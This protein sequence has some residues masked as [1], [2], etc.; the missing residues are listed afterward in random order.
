MIP[1]FLGGHSFDRTETR[2]V[3]SC[4]CLHLCIGLNEKILF[5][6]NRF[7][8]KVLKTTVFL[9][10]YNWHWTKVPT[11]EIH[12]YTLLVRKM[13]LPYAQNQIYF[14]TCIKKTKKKHFLHQRLCVE[15]SYHN[16]YVMP[17]L[18][19]TTQTFCIP[20]THRLLD[21]DYVCDKIKIIT[22]EVYA[23]RNELVYRYNVST[24]A[25]KNWFVQRVIV[26]LSSFIFNG[27]ELFISNSVAVS[28]KAEDAYT[29]VAPSPCSQVLV[30]SELL[31]CFCYFVCMILVTFCC[32][33]VFHV[34]SLSQDYIL[35]ITPI[36]LV[37]L[38]TLTIHISRFYAH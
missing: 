7:L 36:T 25:M 9:F 6:Q 19:D 14:D 5:L 37:A 31:I 22:T 34:W 18:A 26:F 33:S 24:S 30:K 32:V 1:P 38:I 11:R 8:L 20:L 29:I 12:S 10:F 13:I 28:R 27:L 2:A 23:R 15:C 4:N 35:L 16:S 17:E 21:L 3:K